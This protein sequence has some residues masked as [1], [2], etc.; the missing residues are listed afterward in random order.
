MGLALTGSPKRNE[1]GEIEEDEFSKLPTVKQYFKRFIHQ[2]WYYKKV[3]PF[4]AII[5]ST[6]G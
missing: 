1:N 6:F 5:V 2:L 3:S 4:N